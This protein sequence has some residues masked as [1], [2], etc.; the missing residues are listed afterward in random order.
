MTVMGAWL[1][2][3]LTYQE[4]PNGPVGRQEIG[5]MTVAAGAWILLWWP[6]ASR[7]RAGAEDA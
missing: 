3:D 2:Y 5:P 4:G 6:L 1:W 7:R